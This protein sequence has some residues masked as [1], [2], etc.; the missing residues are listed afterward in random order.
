MGSVA[1]AV[2]QDRE[3]GP[4]V[5]PIQRHSEQVEAVLEA[6]V[7]AGDCPIEERQVRELMQAGMLAGECLEAPAQ[8]HWEQPQMIGHF[9]K[10]GDEP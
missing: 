3:S 6:A 9:A 1:G 4:M 7:E 2:D 10:A 8:R 5:D